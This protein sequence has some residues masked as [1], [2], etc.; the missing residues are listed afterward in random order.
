MTIALKRRCFVACPFLI[1]FGRTMRR[2]GPSGAAVW[3]A[4]FFTTSTLMTA[5]ENFGYGSE[6]VRTKIAVFIKSIVIVLSLFRLVPVAL[7]ADQI[8]GFAGIP[9]DTTKSRLEAVLKQKAIPWFGPIQ[10]VQRPQPVTIL[11]STFR[12]LYLFHREKMVAIHVFNSGVLRDDEF[13][14]GIPGQFCLDYIEHI[15]SIIIN[16]YGQSVL[17]LKMISNNKKDE[18]YYAVFNSASGAWMEFV[19]S[20]DSGSGPGARIFGQDGP[21]F[22]NLDYHPPESLGNGF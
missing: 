17:P 9:F 13:H 14:R 19:G 21:C 16:K 15:Y 12:V 6:P 4:N 3:A 10:E 22:V 5:P 8:T 7:A 11:G 18:S 1:E 20:H 2:R